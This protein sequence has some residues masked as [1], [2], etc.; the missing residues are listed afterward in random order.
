M[1]RRR[2]WFAVKGTL[3]PIDFD[4][5]ATF[6]FPEPVAEFAIERYSKPGDWILDPFAGFGTTLVVAERLGRHGVGCEVD[7]RRARFAVGRVPEGRV[8]NIPA[9]ALSS[10]SLPPFDLLVTSPPY[11]SFRSGE[12]D[13]EPETY[14]ADARRLFSGF[15]P[16]LRPQALVVVEVSQLRRGVWTRPLVW[17]LGG[18]LS[19]I[20]DFR[21]DVVRV[22]TD[23]VDAGPGYDHSHLLVFSVPDGGDPQAT[24]NP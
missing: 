5:V 18:M 1:I 4:G 3:E 15:L 20:L 21:E 16:L 14:L 17:E 2:S 9:E 24:M 23:D 7:E 10:L 19:E 13:D 12:A 11:G 8:F 22:N 6:R